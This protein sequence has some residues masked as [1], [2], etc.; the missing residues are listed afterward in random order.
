MLRTVTSQARED[1]EALRDSG[2]QER[3]A[4]RGRLIA[5]TEVDE[6]ALAEGDVAYVLE[7]PRVPFVSYP[8]EWCFSALKAA[9]LLHLDLQLEALAADLVLSDATAYNVQFRGPRPVFIDTLSFERYREGA[10]WLGHRQFCEQFLNPL[11]LRAL[12]GVAHNAWFRGAQEGI[13]SAEMR[14][15]LPLRRKLSRRVLTHVVLPGM[16]G[17]SG[18]GNRT[19]SVSEA[20]KQRG[21]PRASYRGMLEQLRN[22][23]AGLEPKS[24]GKTTWQ[25]YASTHSYSDAE[26]EAK[27]R[28]VAE[29]AADVRPEL[30]FDLGCNTGDYSCALLEAGAG[31]VVGFDADQGALEL[32][33][34]RATEQ[35]LDLLPLYLDAANPPPSQGWSQRERAGLEARLPANGVVALAVVHHLA[36]GRNVPLDA[37]LDWLLSLAPQGVVEFVPK[38]DAMVRELLALREDVFPDYETEVFARLLAERARIV[39]SEVVTES[40][41]TLFRYA[42]E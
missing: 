30:A 41:R 20:V 27:R 4:K 21:L 16:L 6:P 5:A 12:F 15:L 1:W 39:R 25:D 9:A 24:G 28:F 36:I 14:A 10:Y 7:H 26:A 31:R 32:A 23:I 13:T 3:E 40:G 33:F 2:F 35:E 34:A 17:A 11:L 22:W 19:S 37:L 38:G 42:V 8:Y 29:F 18:G